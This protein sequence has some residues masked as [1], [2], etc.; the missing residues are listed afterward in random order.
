MTRPRILVTRRWPA[1]VEAV[2]SERFDATFNLDDI[3]LDAGQLRAALLAYDAVLPTVSDR[4]PATLFEGDA[5]TDENP[6]QFRSRL[7]SYRRRFS[8]GEGHRRH[9]Y[10]GRTDRL[11]RRHRHVAVA[12]RSAPRR[13]RG[14]RVACRRMERLAADAYDRHESHRQNRRHHR[15]RPHRQSVRAALSFWF[16][17][18]CRLLQSFRHRS[19]GS[20]ALRCTCNFRRSRMCLQ[21]PISFR[22]IAL[23][24]RRTAI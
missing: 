4:L 18:G 10:A 1:A 13:G 23:A 21:P 22:C 11:H 9:Q 20:G 7:Q 3:A 24:A 6:G 8:Q 2:L 17:H 15:F 5:I 12:V 14:T 16:R 19:D